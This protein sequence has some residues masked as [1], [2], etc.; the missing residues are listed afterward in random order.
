MMSL[1]RFAERLKEL[2]GDNSDTIYTLGEAMHL[3]PSTISR[4]INARIEPKRSTI[5]ALSRH[6]SV[7]PARLI[8]KSPRN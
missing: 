3:S 2:M 5:E 7:N 6:Y 8:G 4:Y 1:E